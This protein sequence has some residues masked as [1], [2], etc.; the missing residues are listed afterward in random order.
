MPPVSQLCRMI[1]MLSTFLF[2]EVWVGF[3]GDPL[4]MF[5][6]LYRRRF[7]ISRSPRLR[8]PDSLRG[9]LSLT[10]C[11]FWKSMWLG[12]QALLTRTHPYLSCSRRALPVLQREGFAFPA[13]GGLCLLVSTL[14][15]GA[16]PPASSH[17][18]PCPAPPTPSPFSLPTES[19]SG[20]LSS[21]W[22]FC[23]LGPQGLGSFS[24]C[25]LGL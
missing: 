22:D 10:L 8:S 20:L 13:A 5:P 6:L 9:E 11:L 21:P 18:V 7:Q 14:L 25:C 4:V 2:L 17:L 16:G 24:F 15:H 12:P 23:M 19:G 3:S 1:S